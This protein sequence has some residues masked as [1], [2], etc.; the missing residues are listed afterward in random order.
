MENKT[1]VRLIIQ[2]IML[3]IFSVN[4]VL[5]LYYAYNHNYQVATYYLV[6]ATF[7]YMVVKD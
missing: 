2:I 3:L 7:A 4:F 1:S 5:A 6:M